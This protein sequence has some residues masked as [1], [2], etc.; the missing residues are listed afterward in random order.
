M[1]V[2]LPDFMEGQVEKI[3]S[4]LENA[5]FPRALKKNFYH[6]FLNGKNTPILPF[7][8]QILSLTLKLSQKKAQKSYV[9][10]QILKHSLNFEPLPP[11]IS[12]L[13][14]KLC[15]ATLCILNRSLLSQ[16]PV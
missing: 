8:S 2:V 1:G 16:N 7:L 12:G 4:K 9:S 11:L 10:E 3:R 5:Q 6:L 15:H 14:L 13:N